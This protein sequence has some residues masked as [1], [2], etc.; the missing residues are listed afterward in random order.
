MILSN[1]KLE[2]F[3]NYLRHDLWPNSKRIHGQIVSAIKDVSLFVFL[4]VSHPSI[5]NS[6]C[7]IN[8]LT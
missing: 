7:P 1:E 2:M 5:L 8:A 6:I 3:L 4:P